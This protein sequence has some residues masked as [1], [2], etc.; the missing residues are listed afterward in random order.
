[1]LQSDSLGV[2]HDTL[3]HHD[4]LVPR[5]YSNVDFQ[6]ASAVVLLVKFTFAVGHLVDHSQMFMLQ[7]DHYRPNLHVSSLCEHAPL[8][9]HLLHHLFNEVRRAL[10]G[11]LVVMLNEDT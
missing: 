6:E 7:L 5:I 9:F 1:M 8:L 3:F 2:L 10:L 4:N 11:R